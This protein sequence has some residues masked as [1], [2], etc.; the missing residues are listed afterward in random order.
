MMTHEEIVVVV[1]VGTHV[2]NGFDGND[3]SAEARK[4]GTTLQKRADLVDL[5]EDPSAIVHQQLVFLHLVRQEDVEVAVIV[6]IHCNGLVG[7]YPNPHG[8]VYLPTGNNVRSHEVK[9]IG[10]ILPKVEEKVV[11]PAVVCDVEVENTVAIEVLGDHAR[12]GAADPVWIEARVHLSILRV[13]ITRFLGCRRVACVQLLKV[14]IPG[15][16]PKLVWCG[17]RAVRDVQAQSPVPA[18]VER[19]R[20][21]GHSAVVRR[22]GPLPRGEGSRAV[23]DVYPIRAVSVQNEQVRGPVTVAVH[24]YRPTRVVPRGPR[25][26]RVPSICKDEGQ[27]RVHC[28]GIPIV[29]VAFVDEKLIL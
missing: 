9:L 2:L 27:R 26:G 11:R 6:D 5:C 20:I 14:A 21:L 15:A 29:C 4:L 3:A 23:V 8:V 1:R 16:H 13:E 19:D 7:V 25:G 18:A 12:R 10:S 17:S 24:R 22:D 28:T